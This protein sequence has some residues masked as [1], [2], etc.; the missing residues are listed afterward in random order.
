LQLKGRTTAAVST[1]AIL[2]VLV[3]GPGAPADA[4]RSATPRCFGAAAR[5]PANQPCDNPALRL[6]V[7]PSPRDA[8]IEPGAACQRL[9]VS[10]LIAPCAFGPSP[11]RARRTFA[12]VGDSHAAHLRS[13]FTVMAGKLRWR[14][15]AITRNSCPY[16]KTGRP[17]PQQAFAD[18]VEWKRQLPRWLARHPQVDTLF[19]GAMTT[20]VGVDPPD[21]PDPFAAKVN[22]YTQQ[23]GE[24]PRSVKHI[25]VVRD[26]PA[27][28]TGTLPCVSRAM[29]RRRPPGSAC[30]LPRDVAL[31]PDPQATAAAQLGPSRVGL[32]DLTEFFCDPQS[33]YPVV[34]GVLVFKDPNHLTPLFGRTLGPYLARGIRA[35]SRG[36]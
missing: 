29:R 36:G 20:D 4:S 19:L 2:G 12:L 34:G 24:L 17:L 14:G 26:T 32:I 30:A 33:C 21:A 9:P 16:A 13:A 5:D 18:C 10:G 1:G 23:W 28:L 35:L 8:P 22:A 11:A 6:T 7:L 15:L 3:V 31:P 25:V 27:M